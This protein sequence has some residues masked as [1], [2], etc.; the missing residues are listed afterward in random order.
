MGFRNSPNSAQNLVEFP[1]SSLYWSL[2]QL[3]AKTLL[4]IVH[5]YLS[6]IPKCYLATG[7]K[8]S[9]TTRMVLYPSNMHT[10]GETKHVTFHH[11]TGVA[12]KAHISL[13]Y[14]GHVTVRV[15]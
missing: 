2:C 13:V 15:G 10:C 4:S 12:Y 7:Q 6:N 9:Y 1:T 5:A 11:S 3:F 8:L 14:L